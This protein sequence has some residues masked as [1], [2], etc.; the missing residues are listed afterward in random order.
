MRERKA[1]LDYARVFAIIS[2]SSH[3]AITRA[4]DNWLSG[5]AVFAPLSSADTLFRT[6]VFIFSRLGVP[7]FL[8]ITGSL[9]LNKN[10]SEKEDVARFYRRNLG[11]LFI[12]CEIWLFIAFWVRAFTDAPVILQRGALY[13]ILR[14]LASMLFVNQLSLSNM[15]YIPMILCLY[16]LIPFIN[17]LVNRHG[18]RL[19]LLPCAV[20]FLGGMLIPNLIDAFYL[21]N[22]DIHLDFALL[23]ED[24][25]SFYLLYVLAGYW[26]SN[27]GLRKVATPVL[28]V[29]ALLSFAVACAYQGLIF[30]VLRGDQ[31]YY[32]FIP[33][34]LC[35]VC[36]FALFHRYAD[37][38]KERRALTYLSKIA[39]GI[40]FVHMLIVTFLVGVL[41]DGIRVPLAFFVLE[42]ASVG[43]SVAVIAVLSKIPVLK[44]YLFLIKD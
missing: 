3:H 27:D 2:V 19:M 36:S 6:I 22:I 11:R 42:T 14:C 17:I 15:W 21:F 28:F 1:W 12:T 31:T 29:L 7:F 32:N 41:P 20:V 25:F 23:P 8:M 38:L 43:G 16:L 26:I 10:I 18:T 5:L 37:R 33:M 4:V 40:Y 39:F 44:K 24:L 30:T 13:A 34:A 35:A 9:L